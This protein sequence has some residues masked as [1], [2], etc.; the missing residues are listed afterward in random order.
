ME[1]TAEALILP[2]TETNKYEHN[3]QMPVPR[4]ERTFASDTA[5]RV[6]LDLLATESG[7]HTANELCLRMAEKNGIKAEDYHYAVNR[8]HG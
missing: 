6:V 5:V 1:L 2:N 8:G 7:K 3:R 4:F